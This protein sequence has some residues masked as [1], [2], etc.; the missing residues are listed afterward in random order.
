M[1]ET[2]MKKVSDAL[3]SAGEIPVYTVFDNIPIDSKSEIPF[4]VISVDRFEST[5]PIYG[6][7]SVFVPY[8]ATVGISLIAPLGADVPGLYS[9]ADRRILPVIGKIGGLQCKFGSISLKKDSNLNRMVMKID[10]TAQGIKKI[11]RGA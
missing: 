7:N 1:L 2:V 11:S 6:Y 8:T 3:K 4:T 5:P 9:F 10:F